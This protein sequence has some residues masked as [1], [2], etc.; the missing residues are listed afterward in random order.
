MVVLVD[1]STVGVQ[2]QPGQEQGQPPEDASEKARPHADRLGRLQG[3]PQARPGA[4]RPTATGASVSTSPG[5]RQAASL[6][7]PPTSSPA[8]AAGPTLPAPAAL[9]PLLTQ[10]PVLS[11]PSDLLLSIADQGE[12][13]CSFVRVSVPGASRPWPLYDNAVWGPKSCP[14]CSVHLPFQPLTPLP[15]PGPPLTLEVGWLPQ[16]SRLR[17]HSAPPAGRGDLQGPPSSCLWAWEQL[18]R[19][20]PLPS[21]SAA[22]M[23]N[24]GW[25]GGLCPPHPVPL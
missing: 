7:P 11:C 4:E 14:S 21:S 6:A 17:Q 8:G 19:V 9:P 10:A 2:A 13:G 15:G 25:I 23:G 16:A 22:E 20:E 18:S 24:K 1:T 3:C 12:G 5:P